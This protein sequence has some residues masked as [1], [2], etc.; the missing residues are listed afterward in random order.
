ML[1]CRSSGD[2]LQP[3]LHQRSC[4]ICGAPAAAARPHAGRQSPTCHDRP[5]VPV[6]GAAGGAKR[7]PA[8]ALASARDAR[9]LGACGL[10]MPVQVRL[11]H[12]LLVHRLGPPLRPRA[13]PCQLRGS[14]LVRG[15]RWSGC[16][17]LQL[18]RRRRQRLLGQSRPRRLRAL[19]AM[20]PPR[21]DLTRACQPWSLIRHT[22]WRLSC[23]SP[24]QRLMTCPGV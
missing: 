21:P 24:R 3:D 6:S 17:R 1:C 2:H 15:L 14:A 18:G 4:A 5:K 13:K 23:C 8:A 19:Q 12:Q 7:L 10:L 11:L 9:S 16:R 22:K 20:C